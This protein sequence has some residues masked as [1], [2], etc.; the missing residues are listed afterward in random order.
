MRSLQ[1][2][3]GKLRRALTVGRVPALLGAVAI[4]LSVSKN[5]GVWNQAFRQLAVVMTPTSS[6]ERLTISSGANDLPVADHSWTKNELI[7]RESVFIDSCKEHVLADG[8]CETR[9]PVPAILE[10][11]LPE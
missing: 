11:V 2:E 10:Q 7:Y 8:C 4:V 5:Q 1:P 6:I 9:A 3:P